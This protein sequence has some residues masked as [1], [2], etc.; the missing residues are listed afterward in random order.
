M[1]LLAPQPAA[2]ALVL[3]AVLLSAT[4]PPATQPAAAQPAAGLNTAAMTRLDARLSYALAPGAEPVPVWVEFTDKGERGPGDLMLR[5]AAAEAALTSEARHRREKA[6]VMPLVDYLDLPLE[7]AYVR[8]LTE[9]GYA[10]YGQSRWFNRVAVRTSGERLRALTMQS[11]VRRVAPVE[12]AA[13]R[14][15]EPLLPMTPTGAVPGAPDRSALPAAAQALYGQTLTQLQR[16]N[17][18]AVHDSGY[19]GTGI[20]LCVLDDGFNW[21]RKHEALKT[22]PVGGGRTRDFIRGGN[23]VQDTVIAPFNFEHGTATLSTVAGRKSGIY[24]SPAFGCNVALGRTEDSGSETPVEMVYWGMGAEWADSLGCD[25]ITSS[26]GYNLFDGG[27]GNIGYP[28]L[29]GH[30]TVIT[31]AAEIAAA[32]GILVVNSAGNDGNSTNPLVLGKISAPGDAN[33]DSVLAIAAVDS[34]GVRASFSSKGPTY[35]GRIKPDLAAQGVQVLVALPSSDPNLYTRASGTSFSTPLI[36]GIAACLMQARPSWPPVLIVQALKR[37]ASKAASPD[38]LTGWGIPN[39]LAA[40][41]YV[42]DTLDVPDGLGPLALSFA[43]PNPLRATGPAATVR[44]SFGSFTAPASYRVRVYDAGGRVVRDL[45]AGAIAPRSTV[46][47]PWRGDDAHGRAL[48]PGLYFL[49]LDGAGRRESVRVVV[50]R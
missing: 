22:I 45:A 25:I 38:T 35:D 27:I 6:H 36:A 48:V 3:S 2:L 39:A 13:P 31:R 21:Y 34:F 43:G 12:R 40:L 7:P 16:L 30:T 49:T 14:P 47:I 37:T 26:L 18:T 41:R 5:L 19:I 42:P 20:N 17:V 11:F 50:L 44:L 28:M 46:S 4:L 9:Q 33:G 32:K 10:V 24:L 23:D 8:S 29:D 1:R 15:R